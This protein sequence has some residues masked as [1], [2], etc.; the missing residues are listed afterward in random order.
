V[1][2]ILL[3]LLLTTPALADNKKTIY[4]A[5]DDSPNSKMLQAELERKWEKY[6]ATDLALLSNSLHDY[7]N[8]IYVPQSSENTAG[9]KKFPAFKLKTYNHWESF[10][11]RAFLTTSF[12][13]L[14]LRVMID[15]AHT[16]PSVS[17]YSEG[18][19][20]GWKPPERTGNVYF[21][22]IVRKKQEEAQIAYNKRR[23][24]WEKQI[25][26]TKLVPVYGP[27]K[28]IIQ[29]GHKIEENYIFHYYFTGIYGFNGKSW[30]RMLEVPY[31]QYM[32]DTTATL[33]F[34][35]EIR[36]RMKQY[37]FLDGYISEIT[38]MV[39]VGTGYISTI[40]NLDK[41]KIN[42]DVPFQQPFPMLQDVDLELIY[43]WELQYNIVP[44]ER[45]KT[46]FELK[47]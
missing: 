45:V 28:S 42:R 15:V 18:L 7:Y 41:V 35:N 9:V 22:I 12:P 23:A 46:R 33:L 3:F 19:V 25:V 44:P 27:L 2:A 13:L 39:P 34:S 16:D 38:R 47:E 30:E 14:T 11:D 20:E 26:L 17:L 36:S 21:N 8:I 10:D 4:I 32:W 1:K 29:N 6:G 5:I 24:E 37:C 43:P 31:G 40:V